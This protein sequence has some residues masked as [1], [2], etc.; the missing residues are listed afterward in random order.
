MCSV[1]GH[2][3]PAVGIFSNSSFHRFL[4][5]KPV[6]SETSQAERRSNL[7]TIVLSNARFE[8]HAEQ[9]LPRWGRSF[10]RCLERTHQEALQGYALPGLDREGCASV[11][12]CSQSRGRGSLN[13]PKTA[14]ISTRRHRSA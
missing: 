8:A 2:G 7:A 12:Q 1:V 4:A 6:S 10:G 3:G 9:C 5:T 13:R 14:Q 11:W